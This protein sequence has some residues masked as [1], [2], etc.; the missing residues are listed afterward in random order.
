MSFN[1]DLAGYTPRGTAMTGGGAEF[2]TLSLTT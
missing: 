2:L 1:T